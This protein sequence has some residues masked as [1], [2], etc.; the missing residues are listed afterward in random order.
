LL[1]IAR[2]TL[3]KTSA[4]GKR[5]NSIPSGTP[6]DLQAIVARVEEEGVGDS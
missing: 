4:T 6:G 5:L 1:K 2:K 3:F